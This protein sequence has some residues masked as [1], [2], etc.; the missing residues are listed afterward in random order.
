M[1]IWL[2][3]LV[4]LLLTYAIGLGIGWLLFGSSG[5]NA[6]EEKTDKKGAGAE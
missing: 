4:L 5:K 1:P 3:L 6:M 2:E